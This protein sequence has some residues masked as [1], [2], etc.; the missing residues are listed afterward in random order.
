MNTNACSVSGGG[1]MRGRGGPITAAVDGPG[2][3]DQFWRGTID[4]V[5]VPFK[6]RSSHAARLELPALHWTMSF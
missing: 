3:G 2:P 1:T 5:T 6:S 4:G